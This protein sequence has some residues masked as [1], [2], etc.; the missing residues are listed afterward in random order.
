LKRWHCP[1]C[2]GWKLAPEKM[3]A[4]DSRRFCFPC[5]DK[6][7][8]LVRRTCP[9]LDKARDKA[10]A[11]RKA[12]AEAKRVEAARVRARKREREWEARHVGNLDLQAEFRRLL[13]CKA[14]RKHASRRGAPPKLVI[15]RA[16]KAV[17]TLFVW[18]KRDWTIKLQIG[19]QGDAAEA[20]A[21][22]VAALAYRGDEF[23]PNTH[24]LHSEWGVDKISEFAEAA[25][26]I[27]MMDERF[28][29]GICYHS[30]GTFIKILADRLRENQTVYGSFRTPP[31]TGEK[32]RPQAARLS[33]GEDLHAKLLGFLD[34][35][36]AYLDEFDPLLPELANRLRRSKTILVGVSEVD[37]V[38][39]MLSEAAHEVGPLPDTD[40]LLER[41]DKLIEEN[42]REDV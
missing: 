6:T 7:G 2:N 39:V 18:E 15:G 14:I 13:G 23:D 17:R 25:Y 21:T 16:R 41:L 26:K 36:D 9:A 27:P 4:E 34:V 22:L 11:K 38:R 33:F 20:A 29:T 24:S 8:R 35:F 28:T 31:A 42:D 19:T 37:G 1:K 12:K 32:R 3:N 30:V 10:E 40:K 5:S